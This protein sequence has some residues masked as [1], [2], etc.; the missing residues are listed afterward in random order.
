MRSRARSIP[1]DLGSRV[2]VHSAAMP[3]SMGGRACAVR[4][5]AVVCLGLLAATGPRV[6]GAQPIKP[7]VPPSSDSL[8][9]WAVEART[10]FR[11]NTGD[12]VGGDNIK[13]YDLVSRIGR[14]M[15]R[16]LGPAH[17]N[18]ARAIEPAIDSLGL[19]TE[20]AVD[21]DQPTFALLMVHNPFRSSAMSVGWLF[22]YRQNDLRLQGVSFT[23]GHEPRMKVWWSA[24]AGAPYEW[25]VL[26]RVPGKEGFNFTLLRLSADGYYWRADQYEGLGPDLRDALDVGLLDINHDGRPELMAWA[27][28]ESESLFAACSGCPGL[29]TERLYTLARGGYELNDSRIVPTTYSTFVL[30][31]GLLRQNQRTSAARLLDDPARLERAIGLG[32]AEGKGRGLW[33]VEYVDS[34]RAWPRWLAVRFRAPKGEQRWIVHFTQKEGRWLIKDWISNERR[35]VVPPSSARASDTTRVARPGGNR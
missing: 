4:G 8:L 23:G 16:A 7:W 6:A 25:V 28:T 29:I 5:A 24:G 35:A 19:D 10:R 11:A 12:S 1:L 15:L 17:M 18:Q 26:D 33:E 21:P 20:V 14:R 27:R 13:A 34:D 2:Q 22:W 3:R 30:C 31:I 32:W 9:S